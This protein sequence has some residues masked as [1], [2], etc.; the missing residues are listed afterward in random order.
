MAARTLAFNPENLVLPGDPLPH[1]PTP[2][3][4]RP[5]KLGPGI[6]HVPPAEIIPSRAGEFNVDEKKYAVW[7]E[8]NG[9]R[10]SAGDWEWTIG[11]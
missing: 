10:V 8:S 5:I 6:A 4:Q 7:I 2:Q 3:K 9:K 11:H 1:L